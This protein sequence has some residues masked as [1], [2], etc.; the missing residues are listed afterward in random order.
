MTGLIPFK[1]VCVGL[2]VGAALALTGGFAQA[3]ETPKL[4]EKGRPPRPDGRWRAVPDAGRPGQQFQRLALA[5]GQG[6]AG[7]P[8][9][10][11][12]HRPGPDRLGADRADRGQVRLQLSGPA[13]GPGPRQQGAPGAA[14][15]RHLEELLAVLRARVGQAGRQALS[16]SVEEGRDAL[17][18]DVA[19][20]ECDARRRPQGLRGP[21]DPPEGGRSR[22][23][24][25]HD[26]GR[27][28][29]RDLR[30]CPRLF[31]GRPEG[32]RRPRAR[33]P[34]QG[35]EGQARNLEPGLRQGRR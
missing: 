12:Q 2:I 30:L 14:V 27:E 5:D 31:A 15:V 17:L 24:G 22:Q 9:A 34:G 26:P 11:R 8:G 7:H 16:A 3:A 4:V 10:G 23:H 32:V 35:R 29:D 13:A 19:A 1:A 20:G 33:R 28:R 25:D 18:L 21:D 6:L